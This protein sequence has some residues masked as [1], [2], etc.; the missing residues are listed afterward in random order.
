VKDGNR[1]QD[2]N[3]RMGEAMRA[4]GFER[5]KGK[6]V[7][8]HGKLVNGYI[9]GKGRNTLTVLLPT[10]ASSSASP[11]GTPEV[12]WPIKRSGS[13]YYLYYL[14]PLEGIFGE[15]W[16]LGKNTL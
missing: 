8:I 14:S 5:P 1:N 9:R 2:M 6:K 4:I 11:G 10:G 7:R 12:P 3:A 13:L 16:R 15:A